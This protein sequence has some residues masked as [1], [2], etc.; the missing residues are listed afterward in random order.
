MC[1]ILD[2]RRVFDIEIQ[3][4]NLNT[5]IASYDKLYT[6]EIQWKKTSRRSAFES[7]SFVQREFIFHPVVDSM[8]A[9]AIRVHVH[10]YTATIA[11]ISCSRDGQREKKERGKRRKKKGMMGERPLNGTTFRGGRLSAVDRPAARRDSACAL[12]RNKLPRSKKHSR[13]DALLEYL[14]EELTVFRCAG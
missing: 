13:L 2:T 14:R 5:F 9:V 11:C 12:P 8:L 6:L 3:K 10:V 4:F 1:K 7:A